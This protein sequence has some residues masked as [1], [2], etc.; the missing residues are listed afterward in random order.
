MCERERERKEFPF[1]FLSPRKND[2]CP[3]LSKLLFVNS[4]RVQ[5]GVMLHSDSDDV[6]SI[7]EDESP[8]GV[9]VA[10]KEPP[11]SS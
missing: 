8:R 5:A 6:L 7:R 2:K 1:R 3:S 11:G 9:A 4:S 10:S